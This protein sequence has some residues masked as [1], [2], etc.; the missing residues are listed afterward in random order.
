MGL[1]SS[2]DEWCRQ[3]DRAIEGMPFARKIVDDILVWADSL[4]DLVESIRKI[5]EKFK[6]LKIIFS[7]KVHD[8]K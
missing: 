7:K 6:D 5:A 1:S 4:P 8:W 2:S 3:S